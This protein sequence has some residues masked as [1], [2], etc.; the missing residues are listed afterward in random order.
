MFA[1]TARSG[2]LPGPCLA[3]G[4]LSRLPANVKGCLEYGC[5][6]P[7]PDVT[8]RAIDLRRPGRKGALHSW[9]FHT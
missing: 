9:T 8:A 3:A 7:V 1:T 6:P 2:I 5:Q 4:K